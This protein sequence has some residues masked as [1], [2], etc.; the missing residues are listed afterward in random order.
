MLRPA[1]RD[2]TPEPLL[3]VVAWLTLPC[4]IYLIFPR[5]GVQLVPTLVA[6]AITNLLALELFVTA[7]SPWPAAPY[8]APGAL[9]L[10]FAPF[11]GFFRGLAIACELK[12]ETQR[13]CLYWFSFGFAVLCA[14]IYILS[15]SCVEGG[16][17][18]DVDGQV[19]SAAATGTT[20]QGD[21]RV[22]GG[23]SGGAGSESR[24]SSYPPPGY[25]ALATEAK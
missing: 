2:V 19:S 5:E 25:E 13:Q 6:L 16:A 8:C 12:V 3:T 24:S 7:Q 15:Q 1:L 23:R 22:G 17:E 21:S 10:T 4:N 14:V 9:S 20:Q 11:L 18:A